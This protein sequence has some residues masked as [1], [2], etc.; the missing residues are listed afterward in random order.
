M[1]TN[2]VISADLSAGPWELGAVM[3]A[4]PDTFTV[5]IYGPSLSI[6]TIYGA[7]KEECIANAQLLVNARALMTTLENR[8]H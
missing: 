7:T 5:E 8:G 2:P 6:A 3:T 1:S 4:S